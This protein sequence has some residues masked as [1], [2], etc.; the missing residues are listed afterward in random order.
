MMASKKPTFEEAMERLQEI[1]T[2]LESGEETLEE[3]MK[4]FEEGAKLSTFCYE[5]LNHAEQKIS[6]LAKV[7][8]EGEAGHGAV[9]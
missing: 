3:S 2:K 1:V 4:L 5:T 9:E 6:K 8:E 7:D